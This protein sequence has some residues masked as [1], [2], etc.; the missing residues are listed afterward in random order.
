MRNAW[1]RRIIEV[2]LEGDGELPPA[3]KFKAKHNL[4]TLSDYRK[5]APDYFWDSFPTN[6]REVGVSMI[7]G[8]KLKSWLLD[9]GRRGNHQ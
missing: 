7:D 9:G 1:K 8:N 6:M 3:K 2:T 4:P 5:P